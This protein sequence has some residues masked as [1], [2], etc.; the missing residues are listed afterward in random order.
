MA[1]I[2]QL[3]NDL[4]KLLKYISGAATFTFLNTLLP[5]TAAGSLVKLNLYLKDVELSVETLSG[6]P[7]LI[8]GDSTLLNCHKH[9]DFSE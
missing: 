3:I 8:T 6:F 7:A 9:P 5:P 4:Q 1:L 2:N